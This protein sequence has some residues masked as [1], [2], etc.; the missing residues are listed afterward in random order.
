M[1]EWQSV[2]VFPL[3]FGPLLDEILGLG[4]KLAKAHEVVAEVEA[5]YAKALALASSVEA[6][7]DVTAAFVAAVENFIFDILATDVYVL[8]LFPKSKE[9]MLDG[10]SVDTALDLIPASIADPGDPGRPLFTSDATCAG[11]VLMGGVDTL[12]DIMALI[13]FWKDLYRRTVGG[14]LSVLISRLNAFT[15]YEPPPKDMRHGQSVPP[16]WTRVVAGKLVPQVGEV[17]D[18]A[19]AAVKAYDASGK[20]N[21][22]NNAVVEVMDRHASLLSEALG[23][24]REILALLDGVAAGILK[25]GVNLSMLLIPPPEGGGGG[26]MGM[27]A[28]ILAAGNAPKDKYVVG[29]VHL[30]GSASLATLTRRYDAMLTVFGQLGDLAGEL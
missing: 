15:E 5:G 25:P 29:I 7:I 27:A 10:F 12:I 20:F 11:L 24:I 26:A 1:A 9:D 14:D 19:R 4:D 30:V 3:P 23:K 22:L 2:N 6:G 17:I 16:D 28:G 21:N 18:R 13:E 8:P